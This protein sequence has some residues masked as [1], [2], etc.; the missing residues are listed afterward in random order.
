M[1]NSETSNFSLGETDSLT[2][3]RVETKT[4]AEH[5]TPTVRPVSPKCAPFNAKVVND[6]VVVR[7]GDKGGV[8][9]TCNA[10]VLLRLEANFL[11]TWDL[12]TKFLAIEGSNFEVRCLDQRNPLFRVEYKRQPKNVPAAQMHLYAHRDSMTYAMVRAG[13]T[14]KR[15]GRIGVSESPV[16]TLQNLHFPLGG[17]RFRP[18]LEDLIEMLIDEFGINRRDDALE[19]LKEARI[20]WRLTQT[21]AAVRDAPGAA[22]DSLHELGY[23]VTPPS[24]EPPTQR[25]PNRLGAL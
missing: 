22:A 10:E 15:P 19:V 4:F 2:S 25:H 5:L 24:E 17:H 13:R 9:L 18:A 23:Q 20:K 6:R 11:C 8:P 16:P 21:R 12:E 3:L 7:Q 14:S 1:K